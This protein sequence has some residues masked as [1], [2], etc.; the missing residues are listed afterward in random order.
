MRNILKALHLICLFYCNF[1]FGLNRDYGTLNSFCSD[2]PEGDMSYHCD[3]IEEYL[4]IIPPS[5]Q[6]CTHVDCTICHNA[7]QSENEEE[8]EEENERRNSYELYWT[9]DCKEKNYPDDFYK[10]MPSWIRCSKKGI[11]HGYVDYSFRKYNSCLHDFLRWYEENQECKYF[12]PELSSKAEKINNK[13]YR[14]FRELIETTPLCEEFFGS[15]EKQNQMEF[16]WVGQ[17]QTNFTIH[18]IACFFV[19]HAFFYSHYDKICSDIEFYVQNHFQGREK[20]RLEI[21]EKIADI[22]ETL[23]KMFLDLYNT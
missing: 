12:W 5:S 19:S 16:F 23:A 13:A 6:Q 2:H 14:L 9:C 3:W 17:F 18:G 8:Y 10:W 20:Q 22:R 15:N 7:N 11:Y 1:L 4:S 21:Y